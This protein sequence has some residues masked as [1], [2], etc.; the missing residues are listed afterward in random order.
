M[1]HRSNNSINNS[2]SNSINNSISSSINN[3]KEEQHLV[4]AV[5]AQD[6]R[7][8]GD[9]PVLHLRI[10]GRDYLRKSQKRFLPSA[11]SS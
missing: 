6:L 7:R 4:V 5:L 3:T 8:V 9:G 2:K 11:S 10:N 1:N